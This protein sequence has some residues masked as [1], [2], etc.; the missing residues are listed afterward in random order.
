M[1]TRSSIASRGDSDSAL[2]L[3]P[4]FSLQLFH[5]AHRVRYVALPM[6]QVLQPQA[7]DYSL[8]NATRALHPRPVEGQPGLF[9]IVADERDSGTTYPRRFLKDPRI[10]SPGPAVFYLSARTHLVTSENERVTVFCDKG[11][12]T[13]TSSTRI[14]AT[15][16]GVS[17]WAG[18]G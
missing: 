15:R 1:S 13:A 8:L 14:E 18:S 2:P 5:R 6:S 16:P 4:R 12:P 10:P 11:T 9:V 3:R 17:F 7:I